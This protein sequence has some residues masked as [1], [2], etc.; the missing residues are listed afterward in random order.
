MATESTGTPSA[1]DAGV[2][3]KTAYER[4]CCP[5]HPS[6]RLGWCR[7]AAR[8]REDA[9]RVWATAKKDGKR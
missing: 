7:I 2:D 9:K 1:F 3:D 4:G 8:C 5:N 6:V